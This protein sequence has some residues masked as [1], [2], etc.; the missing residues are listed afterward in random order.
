MVKGKHF[1]A[2]IQLIK[3]YFFDKSSYAYFFYLNTT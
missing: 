2:F 3:E 1:K